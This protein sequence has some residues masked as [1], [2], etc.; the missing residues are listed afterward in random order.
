M[1]IFPYSKRKDGITPSVLL[2]TEIC[3]RIL[4]FTAD[5]HFDMKMVTG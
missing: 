1:K 4:S 5:T 2:S 3:E